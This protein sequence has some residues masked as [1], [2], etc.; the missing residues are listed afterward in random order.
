MRKARY[1]HWDL[2]LQGTLNKY[3]YD[4]LLGRELNHYL[5]KFSKINFLTLLFLNLYGFLIS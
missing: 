1:A 4:K 3:R 2:R 5:F